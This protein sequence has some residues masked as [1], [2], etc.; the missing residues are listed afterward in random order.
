MAGKVDM[1]KGLA[2]VFGGAAVKPEGEGDQNA[3]AQEVEAS[4]SQETSGVAPLVEQKAAGASFKA[5]TKPV[6]RPAK[7][8]PAKK[9]VAPKKAVSAPKVVPAPKMSV[10]TEEG[11]AVKERKVPFNLMMPA[12]LHARLSYYADNFAV[13]RNSSVTK[14]ILESV[15]RDLAEL[16]KKAGI[17]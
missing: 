14:I 9:P 5:P 13:G 8:K 4:Q 15:E 10:K 2:M 17:R 16:E 1:K 6:S 3:P 7:K 12:S 11:G